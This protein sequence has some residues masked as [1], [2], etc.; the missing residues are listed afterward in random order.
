[1]TFGEGNSISVMEEATKM[2]KEEHAKKLLKHA[3]A[4][5]VKRILQDY[6]Q[7]PKVWEISSDQD[8]EDVCRR[9]SYISREEIQEQWAETSSPPEALLVTQEDVVRIK[10]NVNFFFSIRK[11]SSL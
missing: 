11:A 8:F 10:E 5:N 3:V 4:S 2:E 7:N 6:K 1:M 9:L